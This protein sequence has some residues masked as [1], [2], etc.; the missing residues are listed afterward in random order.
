MTQQTKKHQAFPES[1]WKIDVSPQV[2][3]GYTQKAQKL[4][5]QAIREISTGLVKSV[6]RVVIDLRQLLSPVPHGSK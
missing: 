3:A 5:A 1:N 6:E 2:I 4:R